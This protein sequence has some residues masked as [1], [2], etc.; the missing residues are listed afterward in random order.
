VLDGNRI[1]S[2]EKDGFVSRGLFELKKINAEFCNIREIELGA[3]NGL[4]ILTYLSL[5]SNKLSEIIPGTFEEKI[6]LEFL[7]LNYNVIEY[8]E[9][10]IFSGL[11]NLK[12]LSLEGNWL[13]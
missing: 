2:F 1:T 12:H 9:S 6:S 11:V 5:K 10:D 13:Q 3:L 8:L 4:K 7:N